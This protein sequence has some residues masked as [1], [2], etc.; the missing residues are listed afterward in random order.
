MDFY[1]TTVAIALL[2]RSR[3]EMVRGQRLDEFHLFNVS[4]SRVNGRD[5]RML[6]RESV[7]PILLGMIATVRRVSFVFP[8]VGRQGVYPACCAVGKPKER[9]WG[10]LIALGSTTRKKKKKLY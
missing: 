5:N 8:R 10:H 2:I 7:I 6:R 3:H 9:E 1:S 4:I